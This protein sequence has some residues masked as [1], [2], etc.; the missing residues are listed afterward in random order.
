V[1][2]R[3]VLSPWRALLSRSAF[4]RGLER[5]DL[6]RLPG[7]RALELGDVANMENT[8]EL[9]SAFTNINTPDDLAYFENI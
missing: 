7:E 2:V 8:A 1:A 9:K 3:I 4:D 6:A 5:R